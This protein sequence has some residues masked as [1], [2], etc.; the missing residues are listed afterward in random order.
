[1][2]INILY[3][4]HEINNLNSFKATFRRDGEIF[5]AE[6]TVE[7]FKILNEHPI[8]IVFADHQMPGT[9]GTAFFEQISEQFPETNRV[10]LTC[11]A[12][13]EEFRNSIK[14]GYLH[15]YVNKP[16]DEEEL[17]MLISTCLI[18]RKL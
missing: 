11:H 7:G 1:M 15:Y 14:A 4:D 3:V 18:P 5:L 13:K 9:T 16:W 6:T 8:D 10:L 17:R 12:F 2:N